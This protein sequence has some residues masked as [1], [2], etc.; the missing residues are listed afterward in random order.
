M[1]DDA[2]RSIP[3]CEE[4]AEFKCKPVAKQN[5]HTSLRGLKDSKSPGPDRI[6]AKILREV[7]ELMCPPRKTI[8]NEL[9]KVEMIP[10]IWKAARVTPIFKSERKSDL[11]NYR[12]ISVLSTVSIIFEKEAGD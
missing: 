10:G 3:S 4:V 9:L 11:N 7:A 1:N 6:L 8:F 12:P 5:I 2:A